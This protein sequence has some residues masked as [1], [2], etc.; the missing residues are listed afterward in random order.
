MSE[1]R[2]QVGPVEVVRELIR[3]PGAILYEARDRGG[4]R[5]LLQ[6]APVRIEP[7]DASVVRAAAAAA[8]AELA[9]DV[10]VY[11]HGLVDQPEDEMVVFWSLPWTEV[12]AVP[13][14]T[15]STPRGAIKIGRRLAEWL[16]ARHRRQ[17]THVLLSQAVVRLDRHGLVKVVGVPVGIAARWLAPTVAPVPWAPEELESGQP[18]LRG[19]LWRLG[20][21]IR[22]LVGPT[23]PI[24]PIGPDPIQ[25]LVERLQADDPDMRPP[26]AEDVVRLLVDVTREID[27]PRRPE[28]KPHRAADDSRTPADPEYGPPRSD[29]EAFREPTHPDALVSAEEPT[30][31]DPDPTDEGGEDGA[32]ILG[33]S[34]DDAPLTDPRFEAFEEATP[35]L[36]RPLE[37]FDDRG[38]AVVA[39]GIPAGDGIS[40]DLAASG[41]VDEPTSVHATAPAADAVADSDAPRTSLP[42]LPGGWPGAPE[43]RDASTPVPDVADAAAKSGAGPQV[44]DARATDRS[45]KSAAAGD[46]GL[47]RVSVPLAP[48]SQAGTLAGPPPPTRTDDG[49]ARGPSGDRASAAADARKNGPRSIQ[50]ADASPTLSGRSMLAVALASAPVDAVDDGVEDLPELSPAEVEALEPDATDADDPARP[51]DAQRGGLIRPGPINDRSVIPKAQGGEAELP[52][53]V[54]DPPRPVSVL[55]ERPLNRASVARGGPMAAFPVPLAAAPDPAEG[56]P[57][58]SPSP[59]AEESPIP[60]VRPAWA[61][62]LSRLQ[63]ME[64][65][66]RVAGLGGLAIG[67]ITLLGLF[68]A[69]APTSDSAIRL[70]GPTRPIAT[71]TTQLTS[72][73]PGA[74][75]VAEDDGRLLGRTPI[76][77]MVPPGDGYAVLIDASGR[78]PMRLVLPVG[79][80]VRVVLPPAPTEACDVEVTG[81][82]DVVLTDHRG[83]QTVPG[84]VAVLGAAVYRR[85]VPGAGA[86]ARLIRC[87]PPGDRSPVQVELA[88]SKK[89]QLRIFAPLGVAVRFEGE[90]LNRLPT[91]VTTERAFAE[92]RVDDPNGRRLIRWVGL[93]DD[94]DVR[95]PAP[96]SA[97]R[98][99]A[100]VVAAADTPS[101]AATAAT[102]VRAAA[103]KATEPKGSSNGQADRTKSTTRIRRAVRPAVLAYRRGRR[104]MVN[105]KPEDAE[106]HFQACLSAERALPAC[107]REL[108]QVY[109]RLDQQTRAQTHFE[110]YLKLRPKAPDVAK[111]RRLVG[112]STGP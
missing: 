35:V 36:S 20:G 12:A 4:V 45:S 75:V 47:R 90:P 13:A 21:V 97:D 72:D 46:A 62:A 39:S 40:G 101:P 88:A 70:E 26:S 30:P 106:K 55:S 10:P 1:A 54:E 6:V 24:G 11:E 42:P 82:A 81:D 7:D 94:T 48:A 43:A 98:S 22:D 3:A 41:L 5:R 84:T 52:A 58:G 93:R 9:A 103:A 85:E 99:K 95:L 56:G 60:Q 86:G 14:A 109:R 32:S 102:G 59:G 57:R 64:G 77:F 69:R 34:R 44:D 49:G 37:G 108:G 17:R 79:G 91:T 51:S 63:S 25:R 110:T 2:R 28:S 23:G 73:P 53:E 96:S 33:A 19:D 50:P 105:G 111:I 16:A 87:P 66:P 68:A 107:H 61:V 8:T 67:V 31:A 76:A 29:P 78:V 74:D 38:V 80:Q 112:V 100:P 104:A 71:L 83:T 89:R 65:W 92:L 18:T 15:A 27:V